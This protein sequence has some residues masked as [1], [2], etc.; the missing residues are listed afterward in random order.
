M[1]AHEVFIPVFMFICIAVVLWKIISHLTEIKN[2]QQSTLQKLIDSGKPLT[3]E[4]LM[5]IAKPKTPNNNKDLSRGLIA[6]SIAFAIFIYGM[7]GLNSEPEF[8]WLAAFPLM[9]GLAFMLIHK[10]R[11]KDL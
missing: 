6:I 5:A 9:L 7:F 8:M 2:T 4:L 11:P 1:P 10:F 3:P